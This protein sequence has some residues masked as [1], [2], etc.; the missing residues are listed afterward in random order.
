MSTVV[1]FENFSCFCD[2]LVF[3]LG[4]FLHLNILHLAEKLQSKVVDEGLNLVGHFRGDVLLDFQKGAAMSS[5]VFSYRALSGP[6]QPIADINVIQ[7]VLRRGLLLQYVGDGHVEARDCVEEFRPFGE[8]IDIR[9]G[10]YLTLVQDCEL[11]R[12]DLLLAADGQPEEPG[13]QACAN[14]GVNLID[15]A[16]FVGVFDPVTG[17]R[18][19]LDDLASTASALDIQL[20]EKGA[21]VSGDAQAVV[22]DETRDGLRR[23]EGAEDGDEGGVVVGPDGTA[24]DVGGNKAEILRCAQNDRARCPVGPGIKG[25]GEKL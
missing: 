23:E 13:H 11:L 19:V 22:R 24:D 17:L 2:S 15:A 5:A 7:E 25:M 16:W 12:I 10:C 4:W 3:L 9:E 6:Q 18:I 21:A 1:P 20:K 8:S 14:D